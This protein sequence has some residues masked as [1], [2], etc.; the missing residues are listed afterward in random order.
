MSGNEGNDPAKH[1][2]LG[3][4]GTTMWVSALPSGDLVD[5]AVGGGYVWLLRSHELLRFPA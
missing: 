4:D 1:P 2:K 5:I 3:P